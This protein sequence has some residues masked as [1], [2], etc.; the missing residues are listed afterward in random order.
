[1]IVRLVSLSFKPDK[2]EEFKQLYEEVVHQIRAH[3][4]CLFVQ[5]VTDTG[6]QGDCYTISHW[7]SQESLDA[8]PH[9]QFFR[10]VWPRIK[11]MLREKPWAQ[12]CTILIDD[13]VKS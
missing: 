2:L 13:P 12:S 5:L 6:G 4:G 1:M 3:P 10:G 8:Y 9:S 11:E 7:R